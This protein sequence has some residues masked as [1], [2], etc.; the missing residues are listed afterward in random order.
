MR[1]PEE[2]EPLSPLR[3]RVLFDET[4]DS[5]ATSEDTGHGDHDA[6]PGVEVRISAEGYAD[7]TYM[8]AMCIMTLQLMLLA[9]GQCV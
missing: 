5:L 4:D 3:S 2:E 1:A 8:L 6:A 9:T 7:D